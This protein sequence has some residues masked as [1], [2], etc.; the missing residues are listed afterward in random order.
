[1][2]D[3]EKISS[4]LKKIRNEV[5]ANILNGSDDIAAY[6]DGWNHGKYRIL[7]IIISEI[8]KGAFD[9]KEA[10]GEKI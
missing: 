1:M 9:I 8:E 5:K 2:L 3:K 10:I 7:T 4:L 6:D